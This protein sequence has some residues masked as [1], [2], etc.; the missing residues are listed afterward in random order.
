MGSFFSV[1]FELIQTFFIPILIESGDISENKSESVCK[2]ESRS[3]SVGSMTTNDG[4]QQK[5]S[6][7]SLLR[8][9]NDIRSMIT[10]LLARVEDLESV[11]QGQIHHGNDDSKPQQSEQVSETNNDTVKSTIKQTYAA[12]VG[13]DFPIFFFSPMGPGLQE[14]CVVPR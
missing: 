5:F 6:S 9:I 12:A 1:G 4:V 14:T 8:G 2:F 13:K 3:W 11:I 7:E 10:A